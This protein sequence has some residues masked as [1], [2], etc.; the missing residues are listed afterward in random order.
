MR[1][2]GW[3]FNPC[4]DGTVSS[5]SCESCGATS[6]NGF[7]PCCD[8]TDSSTARPRLAADRFR[9]VSILVVMERTHRHVRRRLTEEADKEVSILVVMER[10]HRPV[11]LWSASGSPP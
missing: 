10:T 6:R 7:N 3:G 2:P 5:T 9:Q 8:G 11:V 1:S 4:C